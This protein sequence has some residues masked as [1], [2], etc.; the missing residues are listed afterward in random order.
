MGFAMAGFTSLDPSTTVAHRHAYGTYDYEC[1]SY[2]IMCSC[3][4]EHARAY[5][6]ANAVGYIFFAFCSCIRVVSTDVFS[7]LKQ[8]YQGSQDTQIK[9]RE[10]LKGDPEV[11][12]ES[13]I[14]LP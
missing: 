10:I 13:P 7:I 14:K 5:S 9:M 8:I 12:E 1:M 6:R 3:M 4:L 11:K 2:A